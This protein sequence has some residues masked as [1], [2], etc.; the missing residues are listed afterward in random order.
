MIVEIFGIRQRIYDA[1]EEN[2]NIKDL[3]IIYSNIFS[4]IMPDMFRLCKFKI[5]KKRTFLLNKLF[6]LLNIIMHV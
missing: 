6:D 5:Y 3:D 1:K 2:T 4:F